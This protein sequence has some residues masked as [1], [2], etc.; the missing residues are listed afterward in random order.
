MVF[1]TCSEKFD[2]RTIRSIMKSFGGMEA[3]GHWG[4][5]AT[6]GK[7][8]VIKSENWVTLFMDGS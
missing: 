7:R 5:K 2:D 6:M 8:G 4:R 3:R 1:R